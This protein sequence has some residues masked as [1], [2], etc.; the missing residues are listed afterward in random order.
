[1]SVASASREP[2]GR[3]PS[4]RALVSVAELA[5]ELSDPSLLVLDATVVLPS[6]RFDGDYRASSGEAGWAEAHIPGARFADLLGDLSDHAAPY[7][8]AVPQPPAL[9]AALQALGVDDRRRVVI[10]DRESGLWAARLWWMLRSIG[11]AARVLDGGFRRWRDADQPIES[12]AATA[13]AEAAAA[14]VPGLLSSGTVTPGTPT[15]RG[16]LTLRV[17]PTAWTDLPTV[18]AI[19][20]GAAPG[21]LVCALS[22]EVFNGQAP[23][24]Y[25]RRGHIPRSLNY[26]ARQLFD[27]E[28]EYLDAP[29]LAASAAG[30]LGHAERP[31]VLYCGG[32]ISAAATA[33]AL[34]ALGETQLS[35]YDGSLEEWSARQDL[36][37][38]VAT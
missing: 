38:I 12:R 19:A 33:L 35:I 9:A 20:N 34:T 2:A 15:A 7:H 24:R 5:R 27:A 26:P 6:P 14:A 29:A 30:I 17:D 28:G 37:L 13:D 23:T 25:T 16:P 22:A 1:M 11:V 3:D 10:Y 21:T 8:F 31:L 36:P 18:A 32:G 4:R